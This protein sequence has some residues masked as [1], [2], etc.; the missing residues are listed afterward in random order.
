MPFRSNVIEV[1]FLDAIASLASYHDCQLV[2]ILK[3]LKLK[4]IE[5]LKV[6]NAIEGGYRRSGR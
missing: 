1:Q 2:T 4:N 3:L 6:M 5:H